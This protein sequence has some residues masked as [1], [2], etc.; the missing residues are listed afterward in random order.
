MDVPE[1]RTVQHYE[2]EG[3]VG[4]DNTANR[5]PEDDKGQEEEERTMDTEKGGPAK[6]KV[7][8]EQQGRT[9]SIPPKH[10]RENTKRM[11]GT[12]L[13]QQWQPTQ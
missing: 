11:E 8:I 13:K 7:H 9:D 3:A 4:Y 6:K 12:N 5:E 2:I 10:E 1:Q